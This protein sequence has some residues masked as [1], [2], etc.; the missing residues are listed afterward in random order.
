MNIA[1]SINES[2]NTTS[3][4]TVKTSDIHATLIEICAA[5]EYVDSARENDGYRDVW[6]SLDGSD[7]RLRLVRA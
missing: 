3:L 7:F 2:I 6:G 4:V 1:E 5:A